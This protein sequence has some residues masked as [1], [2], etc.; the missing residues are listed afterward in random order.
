[1]YGVSCA[2]EEELLNIQ[3]LPATNSNNLF[4]S[5]GLESENYA[6]ICCDEATEYSLADEMMQQPSKSQI[7]ASDLLN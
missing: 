2:N 7:G 1:V 3:R 6:K 5:R 4:I